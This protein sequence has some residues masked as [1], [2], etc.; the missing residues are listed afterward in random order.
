MITARRAQ[1]FHIYLR[2]F[3]FFSFFHQSKQLISYQSSLSRVQTARNKYLALTKLRLVTVIL[4]D[5]SRRQILKLQTYFGSSTFWHVSP[6]KA[7]FF[8]FPLLHS[9]FVNENIIIQHIIKNSI[10]NYK[11]DKVTPIRIGPHHSVRPALT[12]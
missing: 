1:R 2:R 3:F 11:N 9:Y 8:P 12:G 5:R 7:I 6:L 10:Y 4:C